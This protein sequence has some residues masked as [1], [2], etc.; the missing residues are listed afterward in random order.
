MK[1]LALFA[2]QPIPGQVKTRLAASWGPERAAALYECFLRDQFERFAHE[3][4]RRVVAHSP[5]TV[6]ARSWFSD[7]ADH[8]Q[9]W[10]QPDTDLGG[11][12]A[13]CFAHWCSGADDRMV[14]IGSDSPNLPDGSFDRAFTL[15]ETHDVVLGPAADGGYWLVGLRGSLPEA[16]GIFS[17]IDWSTPDVLRQTVCRIHSLKLT[18]ALLPLWFDVDTV[19]EVATLHGLLVADRQIRLPRT[20]ERLPAISSQSATRHL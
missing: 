6:A 1:T 11:R 18:L 16:R 19:A 4:D 10:P 13:A 20:R 8:W 17:H 12:M 15:L 14:L 9:L 5:G 3:G 2:K 7:A